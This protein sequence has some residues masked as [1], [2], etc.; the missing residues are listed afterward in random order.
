ML[1]LEKS[2]GQ[3]DVVSRCCYI[4]LFSAIECFVVLTF[5]EE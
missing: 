1:L 4:A 3:G 2:F 5:R